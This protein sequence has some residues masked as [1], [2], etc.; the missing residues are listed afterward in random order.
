MS[1]QETLEI[2][3][4]RAEKAVL[5]AA[6][7]EITLGEGAFNRDPLKHAENCIDSMKTCARAAIVKVMGE[8][9]A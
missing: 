8:N 2:K 4:L 6:L 7:G 9:H 5:L 3:K 1:K